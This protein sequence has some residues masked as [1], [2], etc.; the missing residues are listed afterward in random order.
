MIGWGLIHKKGCC[1]A[2]RGIPG[3]AANT[4]SVAFMP[5]NRQR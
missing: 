2:L 1:V 5:F 3:A 4:G